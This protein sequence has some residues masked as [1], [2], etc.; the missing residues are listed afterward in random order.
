VCVCV[1]LFV[2]LFVCEITKNPQYWM[3]TLKKVK[4]CRAVM[5]CYNLSRF[6]LLFLLCKWSLF[7]SAICQ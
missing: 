2:C 4:E 5:L 1:C 6:F 7:F 3:P